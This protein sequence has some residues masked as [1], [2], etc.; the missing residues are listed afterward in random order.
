[1]SAETSAQATEASQGAAKRARA[2]SKWSRW[3]RWSLGATA[4]WLCCI[5]LF[6]NCSHTTPYRAV[7]SAEEP[8]GAVPTLRVLLIGDGGEA[9]RSSPVLAAARVVAQLPA[10]RTVA[11]YLGD[12]IYPD[13]MPAPTESGRAQAEARLSAQLAAFEGTATQLYFTPGNHDWREGAKDG[14]D[15][16]MRERE[17][18]R[19][20]AVNPTR[21][22]PDDAGPG[23]ACVDEAGVRLVFVDSQWWLHQ[24]VKPPADPAEVQRKLEECLSASPALFFTH[25]PP[26]SHGVHGGY[27]TWRD[28]VFPLT[29]LKSWAYLP[30]PLIGSLYPAAR[31]FGVSP[32]DIDHEV[33]RAMI[34]QLSTALEKHPPLVWAAGH[35]H[36]LQVLRGGGEAAFRL[37]SGSGSKADSVTDAPD[38]LYAQE[39]LGFMEILFFE[40][41]PPL[42][43]VHALGEQ[44]LVPTFRLRLQR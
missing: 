30:L 22:L 32:Q 29:R 44:G 21:L 6:T 42:L 34:G 35:E 16:V 12:N 5:G 33:N 39:A 36:N 31:S 4:V 15:A 7:Q 8:S 40:T 24:F 23:P 17:F 27:F 38:T 9:D 41:E 19:E 1:M 20:H 10:G 14:Q 26:Q 13:G 37:V 28:H 18:I 2:R 11:V 43:V 25:H 3:R